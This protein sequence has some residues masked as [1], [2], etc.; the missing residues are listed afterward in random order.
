MRPATVRLSPPAARVRSLTL[1]AA[2]SMPLANTISP[3]AAAPLPLATVTAPAISTAPLACKPSAPSVPSIWITLPPAPAFS[4]SGSW[5]TT[6]VPL[7]ATT[8]FWPGRLAPTA[9]WP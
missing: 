3:P 8:M 5:N 1:P 9:T 2:P 4:T 6:G 7:P